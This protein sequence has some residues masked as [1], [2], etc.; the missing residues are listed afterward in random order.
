MRSLIYANVHIFPVR[1]CFHIG[2]SSLVLDALTK[3]PSQFASLKCAV[4]HQLSRHS[5]RF[6]QRVN[7]SLRCLSIS[8]LTLQQQLG[9]QIKS[10]HAYVASVS[11]CTKEP[12]YSVPNK[13]EIGCLQHS[14]R[15][16]FMTASFT[17][18]PEL[19]VVFS[20]IFCFPGFSKLM[21]FLE[22]MCL[23]CAPAELVKSK[24]KQNKQLQS[25]HNH[26][27]CSHIRPYLPCCGWDILRS[28][29]CPCV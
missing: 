2:W 10:I 21:G 19:R 15:I 1:K 17:Q 20:F 16:G 14:Q 18:S 29:S 9:L 13:A 7:F 8:S 26:I 25:G 4:L 3:A 6:G 23:S 12:E 27:L 28:L 22:S 11:A 24:T 5:G